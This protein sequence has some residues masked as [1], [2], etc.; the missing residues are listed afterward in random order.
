[1][2]RTLSTQDMRDHGVNFGGREMDNGELRFSLTVR[3]S[4][5]VWTESSKARGE[6]QNAHYHLGVG[7]LYI[8][9][10]GRMAFVTQSADGTRHV[11]ILLPGDMVAT[12]TGEHHNLYLFPDSGI[13][14]VKHGMPV[15][16]PEKNGADWYPADLVFDAW[17]KK[18]SEEDIYFQAL[19]KQ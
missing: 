17:T 6:W 2:P 16:N 8:V 19:Q 5:Y 12:V 11:R 9:Q 3:G 14:T 18:L 1:M 10:Y 4:G 15:G 13:H 7:E